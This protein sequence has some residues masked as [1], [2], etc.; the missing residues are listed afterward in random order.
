MK[1][2]FLFDLKRPLPWAA[3]FLMILALPFFIEE[4]LFGFG[5]SSSTPKPGSLYS[6]DS[7]VVP[8]VDVI[9]YIR[10][11]PTPMTPLEV[12]SFQPTDCS[13]EDEP[14]GAFENLSF[15]SVLGLALDQP[16]PIIEP[17]P[18]QPID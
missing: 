18:D 13:F 6:G 12:A 1:S 8:E 7:E 15:T 9:S 16:L 10:T 5:G 14:E 11:G 3:L 4:G 2:S 17:E